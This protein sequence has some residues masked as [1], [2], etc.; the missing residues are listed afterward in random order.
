M[1]FSIYLLNLWRCLNKN[2]FWHMKAQRKSYEGHSQMNWKSLVSVPY[3]QNSSNFCIWLEI[4]KAF[5]SFSKSSLI[6]PIKV[7]SL[8][9]FLILISITHFL[10]ESLN[11]SLSSSLGLGSFL[12]SR[13]DLVCIYKFS[14]HQTLSLILYTYEA[15]F[16]KGS[17]LLGSL[18]F[19]RLILLKE[20]SLSQN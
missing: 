5:A 12:P 14:Q 18:Q 9:Y 6:S 3:S 20:V 4:L 10:K 13:S 7:L 8:S 1:L 15:F 19:F 16:L 11:S 17:S 2:L